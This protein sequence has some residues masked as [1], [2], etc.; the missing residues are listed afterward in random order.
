MGK[1]ILFVYLAMCLSAWATQSQS[2]PEIEKL[3]LQW[4]NEQQNIY[5]QLE[6]QRVNFLLLE[7]LLREME[8]EGKFSNAIFERVV[9]LEAMLLDYPLIEE[10]KWAILNTKLK[11][12]AISQEEILHFIKQYPHIAKRN[13]LEQFPIEMWYKQQ[14]WSELLAY[15]DKVGE[16]SVANQCR[17]WAA[18][19]QSQADKLQL[20]P[21][22][23]QAN[24]L[25]QPLS[26]ELAQLLAKFDDFWINNGS[27]PSD[28]ANLEAF[29]RDQGLKTEDKVKQKA[30]KLWITNAKAELSQLALNNQDVELGKWLADLQKLLSEPNYLQ[31]FIAKQP[32]ND[33]NKQL[34]LHAFP[35]FLKTLPE[36]MQNVDFAPY[37]T[38]A[39]QWQLSENQV[40]E[41][42][43]QFLQRFFDNTT[44]QFQ[45]WRD[46]QL[47]ELKEDSLTERR[48]RMAIWQKSDLNRWLVLLSP[49]TR[50]KAEWRYW[51]AK[52]QPAQQAAIFQQLATERGFYPMLAA[53]ALGQPYQPVLPAINKLTEQQTLK[54]KPQLNRIAELRA[55]KR[56]SAAK[57]VWVD[58]LQAASF[59][60]KIALSNFALQ[61]DWF[62]LAVEGTIQAKAWDYLSLR[63]PNA[64]SDWF[65]L[66]LQ[67]KKITKTFAM[68]IARQE[69]AWN[70]QA[71]SHANA[72]GLMQLLPTTASQTAK[73]NQLSYTGEKDLL[74]PFKNIMLGTAH[75]A[76]LNETYPNN[77]ILIAAAYNAGPHRVSRWLERA[78][79]TL[80]MDEFIA[81]IPFVETR[82]YVQN[83][84]AYDYYYQ[85]LYNETLVLFTRDE[86]ERRY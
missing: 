18:Q 56:L 49:E 26:P 38:W 11:L 77:R 31:H 70:A 29:W 82:G 19:Y 27:L 61:Q 63:L 37:Q 16:L 75:L 62:D 67:N 4:Q 45:Q 80:A 55:L 39:E 10:I 48:L 71:R 7:T 17:V 1:K 14:K 79:G 84:L 20:N 86:R 42:K 47:A 50:A 46:A 30:V 8:R 66:N 83:V 85:F 15:S 65:E 54:F 58:L 57:I 34:V 51:L 9:H 52:S 60:E 28:C 43:I 21:E 24:N 44:P 78:N 73:A 32:L 13:K 59:D 22:A 76:E 64:Y 74:D 5:R 6:K 81:S 72:I 33:L 2:S 12:N 35:K 25:A 23:A 53:Q 40:R 36:Q 68:A 3:K 69:S 41:W